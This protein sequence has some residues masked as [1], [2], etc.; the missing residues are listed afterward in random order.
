MKNFWKFVILGFKL[1]SSKWKFDL[2]KRP[3]N[4]VIL[5]IRKR[6]KKNFFKKGENF[7]AL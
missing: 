6:L 1:V 5:S 4:N 7:L 2:V 3:L